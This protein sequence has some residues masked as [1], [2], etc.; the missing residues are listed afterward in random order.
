[1]TT[2][3]DRPARR[4]HESRGVSENALFVSPPRAAFLSGRSGGSAPRRSG[5]SSCSR[6]S[7]PRAW[8]TPDGRY[9]LGGDLAGSFWHV[10]GFCR[11]KP[12]ELDPYLPSPLRLPD[13]EPLVPLPPAGV[14]PTDGATR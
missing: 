5:G 8:F 14:P 10:I 4:G 12:G 2:S 6:S 11:F 7:S 9:K 3:E 1:V 13:D